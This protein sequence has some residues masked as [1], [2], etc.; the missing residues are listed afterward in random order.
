MIS[1]A[2]AFAYIK[3]HTVPTSEVVAVKLGDAM[4][5]VVAE[6]IISPIAMPPFRQSAM[7]GYA[8]HLHSSNEYVLIGEVKAG[9][10]QEPV[11]QKG[12]AVR[13]F[14]GARVPSTANAVVVQEKVSASS[15]KI[16]VLTAVAPNDNIRPLGEQV[17]EGAVALKKGT[18]INA[19]GIGFMA[20]LGIT[21]LH[22][23][24][25]PAI[26]LLATGNE[27]MEAGQPLKPGKI[28]ESNNLMVLSQLRKL[29]YTDVSSLKITDDYNETAATLKEMI[30]T[31]DIV[32][33]SGGISVGDY[34]F[35]GK[36][37]NE[38]GVEELF[39][40]V[41]QKPGKPLYFGK[42]GDTL[43]F[44][45]PGNPAAFLSCFYLYVLLAL[46]IRSG[47]TNFSLARTKA[48]STSSFKSSLGRPQFLKAFYNEGKVSI[49]EGQNSSMLH[50]FAVSN[51]LVFVPETVTTIAIND[52][53]E[54]ILLP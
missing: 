23:F 29:G 6:D 42:Q 30:A 16:S 10:P 1:I 43:I 35:V 28:Y 46:K 8:V 4:D 51:A 53:L 36:A 11:L 41:N 54:V 52:E 27:L 44:A 49:L 7:D 19:A 31:K 26:C 13:I 32:L 37:L 50:T 34:D 24:K 15:A 5:F 9:D 2:D 45:L 21:K 18:R 47:D 20:S 14:T 38:L 33:I 48:I 22:V 40:K 17:V 12:E 39:Y 25:N 3:N